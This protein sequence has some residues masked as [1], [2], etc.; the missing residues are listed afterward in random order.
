MTVY[1]LTL[2]ALAIPFFLAGIKTH[3]KGL[4]PGLFL[5]LFFWS[6]ISPPLGLVALG[7][8]A[9]LFWSVKPFARTSRKKTAPSVWLANPALPIFLVFLLTA[10]LFCILG[11]CITDYGRILCLPSPVLSSGATLSFGAWLT[12]PI[13][14]GSLCDRKGPFPSAVLLALG[15]ELSVL[16]AALSSHGHG[17]FL[18]GVFGANFC[19]SGFFIVMPMICAAFWGADRFLRVYPFTAL[20]LALLWRA[21]DPS[22]RNKNADFYLS[23]DFLISLL[24]LSLVAALFLYMAWKK[25]FVLLSGHR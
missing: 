21:L 11:S 18:L 12:A 3:R 16:F 25:R 13:F 2:S 5:S 17:F 7:S 23:G 6:R 19:I 4:I 1:A 20:T 8:A 14:F 9:Y 22:A 10:G 24:I 15:A